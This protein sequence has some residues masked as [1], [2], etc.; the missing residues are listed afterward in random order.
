MTRLTRLQIVDKTIMEADLDGDGKIS[1]DE[2][3]KMVENTDVSMSMTLGE[4]AVLS[5]WITLT[6]G[7][8]IL[9][10]CVIARIFEF[11]AWR[12]GSPACVRSVMLCRACNK[13]INQVL[14]AWQTSCEDFH[15]VRLRKQHHDENIMLFEKGCY[16]TICL[17]SQV[18]PSKSISTPSHIHLNHFSYTYSNF[19]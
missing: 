19:K 16:F 9:G 3:Q 7:R 15:F 17:P 6:Q 12:F 13:A 11:G 5:L 8:S 18:G 4:Q 1:F 2:F 14:F 10:F